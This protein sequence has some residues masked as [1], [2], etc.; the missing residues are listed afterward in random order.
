[1]MREWPPRG[2]L[3]AYGPERDHEPIEVG[4]RVRCWAGV[5]VVSAIGTA[6]NGVAGIH[7]YVDV[8]LDDGK[9]CSAKLDEL[10]VAEP[11]FWDERPV[12]G[13]MF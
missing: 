11:A 5:G 8:E 10:A 3:D 13:A 4:D 12:E 6:F 7:A 1:M 9:R 2:V